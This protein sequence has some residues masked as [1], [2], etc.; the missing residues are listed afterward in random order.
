M[1]GTAPLLCEGRHLGFG[2]LKPGMANRA[3]PAAHGL[4]Q[5]P[6]TSTD[7]LY[8]TTSPKKRTPSSLPHGWTREAS[9]PW[10]ALR[11]GL[12]PPRQHGR[13][14]PRD[15]PL[16]TAALPQRFLSW[17]RSRSPIGPAHP[18]LGTRHPPT[19]RQ[20]GAEPPQKS[21]AMATRSQ[22]EA[23]LH[24][25]EGRTVW[26]RPRRLSHRHWNHGTTAAD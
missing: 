8:A 2:T 11:N 12:P 6:T 9:R 7:T 21:N 20:D 18:G 17:T 26:N 14:C 15:V 4:Q 24:D 23:Q 5:V 25:D 3:M 1:A 16:D 13:A 19:T 10:S 22:G